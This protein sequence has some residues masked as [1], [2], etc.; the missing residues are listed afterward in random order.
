VS[1]TDMSSPK[2]R[3][4]SNAMF[5]YVDDCSSSEEDV[6]T[7]KRSKHHHLDEKERAR[8]FS[9]ETSFTFW[10]KKEVEVLVLSH[11]NADS[12]K[13]TREAV[14]R[15]G[16]GRTVE[17][18]RTKF[19]S[20]TEDEKQEIRSHA[21]NVSEGDIDRLGVAHCWTDEEVKALIFSKDRGDPWEQV[22]KAVSRKGD[23][24]T[25]AA[26]RNKFDRMTEDEKDE[27]RHPKTELSDEI[28]NSWK[29]WTD[30]EIK[31]LKSSREKGGSWNLICEAVSN[32]GTGR[33]PNACWQKFHSLTK[34]TNEENRHLT[35]NFPEQKST[36][37]DA[38]IYWTRKEV[39]VLVISYEKDKSW[40]VAS[41][42]VARVGNG[43]S[44]TA[45]SR[46]VTIDTAGLFVA[47]YYFLQTIF[48]FSTLF[49][50]Q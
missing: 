30:E 29:P 32:V 45:V 7:K 19:W 4:G 48:Y 21:T 6:I 34:D 27:I 2:K 17:A 13:E 16:S 26:C 47:T 23:G 18:C 20:M 38:E 10:T 15:E 11:D 39:E 1:Q 12:W 3:K 33:T 8:D 28:E 46:N 35:T 44:S 42:A 37:N 31:T 5:F 40:D 36:K 9:N 49:L 14:A 50:V 22:W 41:K 24:R 25:M 43:R